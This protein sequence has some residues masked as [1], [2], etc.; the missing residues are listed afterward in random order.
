MDEFIYFHIAFVSVW[1][2]WRPKTILSETV[3]IAFACQTQNSEI[4]GVLGIQGNAASAAVETKQIIW[5]KYPQ[6]K[7][8]KK[9][10]YIY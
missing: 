8:Q 7:R 6:T 1:R 3:K 5:E 10:I 9:Y 4:D 2:V